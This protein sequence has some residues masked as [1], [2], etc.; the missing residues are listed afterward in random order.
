MKSNVKIPGSAI[1]CC[2]LLISQ[3]ALCQVRLPFLISDGMV[4]QRD[5]DVKIWGWA[6]K[7]EKVTIN[8]NGKTYNTTA[9]TD[10]KWAVMLFELKAGGPCSMDINAGNH[11][12]LTNIMI[13]DVWVCSGQSN[14]ELPMDRVKYRYPDVIAN[15][16]NPGIRQFIVPHVYD[17]QGP[18][19]DL[20]SG[21]WESA[22]PESVLHFSAVGYFFAKEL[23][24]KYH[25]PIGLINASLGGSPAQ[26]WLSEDAL[27]AFPEYLETA[28][29]FK[30]S[31]YL[32]Q[33]VEKDKAVSDAWY[34]RIQQLDKGLEKGQKPWFDVNYDASQWPTMNV[35]G[36][37]ADGNLGNVNGVVW[38]RKEI[39]VP[40]SMTGKPAKLWLG[41]IVDGDFTY[42]NGKQVGSVSYQYPPRIY[43]IPSN[44]LQA[45][46][47][48]ITV[49]V[50]SN[51]GRGGFV[52]DK[53]Y[54]LTA[55]EQ[56]IDLKGRWQYRLGATMDPLPGKT[57]IEWQ[58]AGLYNGMVAPLLNY[59]IKGVIWYQG[60]SNTAKPR[61]Y[62]KLFS[63]VIADWRGKWN[64]GDFPFLY[65]QLAN[66]MDVKDQPS[67]SGWAETRE[68]QLKTLAVPNTGM[69]VTIDLGEWNDIHPLNKEDVGKRLALAAQKVAYGDEKA[70]YSGPIYQSKKIEGNKV[71]LTF[72]NTGSGLTVKGDGELK[73]FAIAGADKK[74][75]WAKAKI[76]GNNVIV[77]NDQVANPV[78]VRYAWADNPEGANLYNKEG[79]P[80]SPF[81]ADE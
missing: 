25:V 22:N 31:N 35:P 13:G 12:I 81:G 72:T 46:K 34:S 52:L 32:N 69:V 79:L 21:R 33:I 11:I 49:R 6:D 4:M 76:E 27:K 41:R 45:G 38:F 60:E 74:F 37:W 19:E 51:S 30:D 48:I 39:N 24:E 57:F 8:F 67:E 59:K 73:Y 58:P 14:M 78:A 26:A 50:I 47:N 44:L 43:D 61:E 71:I 62:Q 80:A 29:K 77:W 10:G 28:K 36:Y 75:V 18:R 42:V 2:I 15:A 54:R 16:E 1:L 20:K 5:A 55:G 40:A 65:V 7:G 66:F 63:A 53:P 56:T 17:F 64:Q 70:V 23:F 3:A 9:G 68:A